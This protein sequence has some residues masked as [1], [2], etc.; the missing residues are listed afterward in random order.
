MKKTKLIEI[1]IDVYKY[2]VSKSNF[3]DE[4]EN[5]ILRRIFN[6]KKNDSS[7]TYKN[8]NNGIKTKGVFLANGTKLRG[9]YKG[10]II[11]GAIVNNKIFVE[12]VDEFFTSFSSAA[13][14]ITDSDSSRING[15]L[16]WEYYDEK[17]N[18]WYIINKL[19]N[20]IKPLKD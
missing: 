13:T 17:N 4:P 9:N 1:D 6:L 14:S 3:I 15:W 7:S 2:I 10:E 18:R 11:N 5:H 16:F 12:Q 8:E 20:Q 19:R